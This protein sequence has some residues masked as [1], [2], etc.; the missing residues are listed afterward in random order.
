MT[1]IEMLTMRRT[2]NSSHDKSTSLSTLSTLLTST[3]TSILSAPSTPSTSTKLSH[4]SSSNSDHKQRSST[5]ADRKLKLDHA[6]TDIIK[7]NV[8]LPKDAWIAFKQYL[9]TGDRQNKT[10]YMPSLNKTLRIKL[11]SSSKKC[12]IYLI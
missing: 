7:Q 1:T 8:N 4:Q 5:K 6:L 9:E 12:R 11:F 10:I 2:A 3:S